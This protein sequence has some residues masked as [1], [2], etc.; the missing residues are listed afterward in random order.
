MLPQLT[1]P[2][3]PGHSTIQL[4]QNRRECGRFVHQA[5]SDTK[6]STVHSGSR[7]SPLWKGLIGFISFGLF[8]LGSIHFILIVR[9]GRPLPGYGGTLFLMIS[10]R[11]RFLR[12]PPLG[13]H[14]LFFSVISRG[15]CIFLRAVGSGGSVAIL[16]HRSS[17]PLMSASEQRAGE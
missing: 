9:A 15:I 10:H 3:C 8:H 17:G 5:P 14:I 2:A 6:A 7:A 16:G 11:M 4:H 12:R 1:R 13:I